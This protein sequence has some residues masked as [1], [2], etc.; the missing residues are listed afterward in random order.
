M[1]RCLE[2]AL[3]ACAAPLVGRVAEGVFGF[4]GNATRT[5]DPAE[6]LRRARALGNALMIFLM[7]PW[8]LCLLSYTGA[9]R[10]SVHLR[11]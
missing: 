10:I 5:G 8:A 4:S 2:G 1:H 3:A 9:L 7:V 6:D 11:P